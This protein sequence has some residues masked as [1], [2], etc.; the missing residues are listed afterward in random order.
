M[1]REETLKKAIECVCGM[2]EQ[3]Y[4][5]PEDNFQMIAD[6]WNIYIQHSPNAHKKLDRTDV[7]MMM[8]LLKIARIGTGT[9]TE[10]SFVDLAG[11]AACGAEVGTETSKWSPECG[12]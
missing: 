3:D 8:A 9:G 1:T 7:A 12:A 4:G 5:S 6:L 11:Y 2:R 10:D